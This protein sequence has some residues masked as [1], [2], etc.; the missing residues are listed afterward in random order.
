[1][2]KLFDN[3]FMKVCCE[4]GLTIQV[5]PPLSLIIKIANLVTASKSAKA[6]LKVPVIS[7]YP[8]R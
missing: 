3:Q 5:V 8:S 4:G 2:I 1:M 7:V 6:Y